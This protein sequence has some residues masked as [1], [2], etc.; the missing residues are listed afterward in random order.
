MSWAGAATLQALLVCCCRPYISVAIK[1]VAHWGPH[2]ELALCQ[3]G[4]LCWEVWLGGPVGHARWSI[5]RQEWSSHASLV[6]ETLGCVVVVVV[7]GSVAC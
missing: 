4:R 1:V 2:L 5:R 7:E 3:E 6:G